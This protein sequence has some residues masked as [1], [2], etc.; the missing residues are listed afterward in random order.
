MLAH[1][2]TTLYPDVQVTIGPVIE[3]G[4]YY[5]FSHKAGF[6][7]EELPAIEKKMKQIVKQRLPIERLVWPRDEAIDFSSTGEHYKAEII[8]DIDASKHITI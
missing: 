6:K 5:D 7:L 4:F 1:A 3:N 2:V 8:S